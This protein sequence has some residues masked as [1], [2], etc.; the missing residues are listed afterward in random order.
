MISRKLHEQVIESD[1]SGSRGNAL[2]VQILGRFRQ[3]VPA[4]A[5]NER[6]SCIAL[7]VRNGVDF[8]FSTMLS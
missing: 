3:C 6:I 5:C 1:K 2:P 8:A 7:H 4:R